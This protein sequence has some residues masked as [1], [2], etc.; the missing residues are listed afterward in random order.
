MVAIWVFRAISV[1]AICFYHNL[2]DLKMKSPCPC[3]RFTRPMR[4]D[5]PDIPSDS[6]V[7]KA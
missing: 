6:P 2:L 1:K 3:R 4:G 7:K 5:N